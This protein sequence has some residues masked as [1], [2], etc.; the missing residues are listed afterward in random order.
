M[1]AKPKL[2]GKGLPKGFVAL[3]KTA[4]FKSFYLVSPLEVIDLSKVGAIVILITQW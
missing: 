3:I 2:E 1:S 4:V